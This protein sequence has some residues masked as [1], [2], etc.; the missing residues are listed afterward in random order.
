MA[1][2]QAALEIFLQFAVEARAIT[3]SVHAN[4]VPQPSSMAMM[5]RSRKPFSVVMS[6]VFSSACACLCDGQFP[7]RTPMDLALF[8]RWMPAARLKR[9][10]NMALD[11]FFAWYVDDDP[12]LRSSISLKTL[13][14]GDRDSK[15]IAGRGQNGRKKRS[16]ILNYS[17]VF[18]GFYALPGG[19]IWMQ[20]GK[21]VGGLPVPGHG[22]TTH[23]EQGTSKR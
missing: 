6:G 9:V 15:P 12:N 2:L 3:P 1:E 17:K 23:T 8:T 20:S 19:W 7:I 13:S 22:D 18:R 14:L 16:Y 5:A 21:A 4:T 11:E 10:Y